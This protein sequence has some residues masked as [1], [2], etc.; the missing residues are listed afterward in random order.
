MLNIKLKAVLENGREL[1]DGDFWTPNWQ[2]SEDYSSRCYPITI[3]IDGVKYCNKVRGKGNYVTYTG[4][5]GETEDFY[6]SWEHDEI[7]ASCKIFASVN[8]GEWEEIRRNK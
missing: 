1:F 5:D 3:T 4:L 7:Y 8:N 6:S 2:V